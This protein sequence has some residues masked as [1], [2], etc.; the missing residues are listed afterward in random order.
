MP[1]KIS[2]LS[3]VAYWTGEEAAKYD[4]SSSIKKTQEEMTQH[5]MM[6][7]EL[8]PRSL[9]LDVGCGTGFS[10]K[11]IEQFGCLPIGIDVSVEMLKL[12][13]AKGMRLLVRGDWRNLPFRENSLDALI[14]VSTL[15]W[16]SGKTMEDVKR[17]YKKIATESNRVLKSRGKAGI[18]FYP[19]TSAEFELVKKAFKGAAFGGHV[20]EEGSGKKLKRYLILQ[21]KW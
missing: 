18:Q 5:I 15:Q 3:A 19:A 17:Q 10:M 14:S 13:K 1:E 9:V 8:P 20:T 7:L 16:I 21:K 11:V 12:A 4:R 2:G 6:E